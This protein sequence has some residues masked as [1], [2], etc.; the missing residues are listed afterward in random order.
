MT[1]RR[2]ILFLA[3]AATLAHI[4]RPLVL[5][6]G[7]N[8]DKY[9][10]HFASADRYSFIFGAEKFRRWP[11]TSLPTDNFLER[12]ARGK[13][14]FEYSIIRDYV[15]D[16]ISLFDKVQPDIV[17]GD[18]RLSL[19]ISARIARL[20][21]CS[22]VNAYW[23]P[24][25]RP[26]YIVPDHFLVR[27]LGARLANM[28]F[29]LIAPLIMA[30][31][32]LPMNRARRHFKL[33]ML[34]RLQQIYTDADHV[35]YLD[36]PALIPTFDLPSNHRYLG[37]VIWTPDTTLPNWWSQLDSDIPSVY[38]TLGSSGDTDI[39]PTVLAA[40]AHLPVSVLVATAGRTALRTVPS[41]VYFADYLPGSAAAARS[42]LVICNGGSPTTLQALSAGVPVIGIAS[43]MD[44][45]L[46]IDYVERAGAGKALRA[47]ALTVESLRAECELMLVEPSYKNHAIRLQA[48]MAAYDPVARLESLLDSIR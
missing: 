42:T 7:L 20:P 19:Q 33:S 16:D 30:A 1:R 37:P 25:A 44:Q 47:D 23:S 21:Y 24:F 3:E 13:P 29:Q 46:N 43:N 36:V 35:L 15:D 11:L 8:P 12:V 27:V 39:L 6:R 31:H 34:S 41:N 5:A 10:I 4:T 32:T 14:I 2:R 26:N 22:L 45:Y 9:E 28:G 48:Q 38:V 17:I 40:L 18:L